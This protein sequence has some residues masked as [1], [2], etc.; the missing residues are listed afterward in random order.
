MKF[1]G[2][3]IS[4]LIGFDRRERRGTF[5]LAVMVVILLVV[6][7]A[8]LRPGRLPDPLPPPPAQA[9]RHTAGAADASGSDRVLPA[10]GLLFPFDPNT[11]AYDD[12]VMLGLTAR[13]ARTL[14]N[15]RS[16]GARFRGPGDLMRVYGMGEEMAE[17]L[18]PYVTAGGSF[19][20]GGREVRAE[21]VRR[22]SQGGAAGSELSAAKADAT[23]PGRTPAAGPHT[24]V[25]LN[26]CSAG[27]LLGMPGIGPVL[28]ERIVK[29]RSLL[30]G[31]VDK[32]QLREVYG[33]DSATAGSLAARTTLTFEAVRPIVL[34][35]I[36]FG[37]LARH[38][39]LG[40]ETARRITTYRRLTGR[41]VTLGGMVSDG[42]LTHEQAV[43]IAPYV[44][45]PQDTVGEV[46]EFI[47]SKV[48]K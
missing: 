2:K 7:A 15:Y 6:R 25:D 13:Q 14:V 4:R 18:A 12:L 5:V 9:G 1:T 17:R 37:D 39:Y 30:G 24:T 11:A 3:A 16:S 43:R 27:E 21:V 23:A 29:Y 20:G 44:K 31:F 22:G 35:S 48:L 46:Y 40:H 34:E 33:L 41:P 38:P 42:A 36:T 26:R 10:P 32:G 8:A 28:S 19:P 45:P 47:L